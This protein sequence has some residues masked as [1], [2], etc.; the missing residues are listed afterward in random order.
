MRKESRK[1]DKANNSTLQQLSARMDTSKAKRAKGLSEVQVNE[2]EVKEEV[3]KKIVVDPR[4]EVS[5]LG[6][7]R[8]GREIQKRQNPK[9]KNGYPK[10]QIGEW[11]IGLHIL[12][13]ITFVGPRPTNRHIGNHIDGDKRNPRLNNLE[14]ITQSENIKHAYRT[15]LVKDRHLLTKEDRRKIA[16]LYKAG[17]HTPKQIRALI[18]LREDQKNVYLKAL[19]EHGIM[20]YDRLKKISRA[21]REKIKSE[22]IPRKIPKRVLAEKYG[23]SERTIE[24]II[25]GQ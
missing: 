19:K 24:F 15:G 25:S 2:L 21:I 3:W 1:G 22:Y 20:T 9:A 16:E 23:I 11:S 4:Y 8:K 12:V 5:T 17:E 14:W 13:L 18:G 6:R 7:V 10:V